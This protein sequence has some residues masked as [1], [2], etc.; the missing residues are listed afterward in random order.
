MHDADLSAINTKDQ[1]NRI[2][3]KSLTD[4]KVAGNTVSMSLASAS[5]TSCPSGRLTPDW[6][7][8]G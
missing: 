2:E 5:W 8:R 6:K 1:P 4:I 3:P 7:A